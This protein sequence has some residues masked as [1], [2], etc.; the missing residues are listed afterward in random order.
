MK[1]NKMFLLIC[2]I[3]GLTGLTVIGYYVSMLFIGEIEYVFLPYLEHQFNTAIFFPLFL[4]AVL[5][6]DI[7]WIPI[8]KFW[9]KNSHIKIT[10]SLLIFAFNAALVTGLI[11]AYMLRD[12]KW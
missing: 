3:I 6:S 4:I 10:L 1:N 5:L 11:A 8:I 12:F 2:E 9:L 7:L